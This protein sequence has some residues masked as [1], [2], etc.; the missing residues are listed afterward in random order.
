MSPWLILFIIIVV[1]LMIWWAL[2][3]NAKGYQPDFPLHHDESHAEH[4]SEGETAAHDDAPALRAHASEVQAALDAGVLESET[5]AAHLPPSSA[6]VTRDDASPYAAAAA[7]AEGQPLEPLAP[8]APR[9]SA[10]GVEDGAPVEPAGQ[11]SEHPAAAPQAPHTSSPSVQPDDLIIIEGIGPKVNQVLQAAGIYTFA[12]L[13][14]TTPEQLRAILEPAGFRF[15]DPSS[16]PQQARL[17]GEGKM[18]ELQAYQKGLN[19]GKNV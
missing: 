4:G 2:L 16:W 15:M 14:E 3:R 18:E 5:S 10:P 11:P 1:V 13:A 12:Q 19:A 6:A 8:T 7:I 17:A 9:A